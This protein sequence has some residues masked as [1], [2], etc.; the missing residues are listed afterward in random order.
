MSNTYKSTSISTWSI[1]VTGLVLVLLTTV[2]AAPLDPDNAAL[3]YYQ[4]F[5]LCP[6]IDSFPHEIV[7][8][9]YHGAESSEDIGEYRKYVEGYQHVIQ[10]V[11][12]ASNIQHCDW[13]IP[14]SIGWKVRAKLMPLTRS[15]SFL[16]A[17]NSRV[18]AA[19]GDYKAALSQCF[20]LRRVARHIAE[21]PGQ[22]N[23]I[24][25]VIEKA[26][27]LCVNR[28]LDIMPPDEITLK[29]LLG[30]LDADPPISESLSMGIKRDFERTIRAISKDGA[31]LSNLRKKLI[32]KATNEEQRNKAL[33]LTAEE[34][35][36]LIREP[37]VE[38]LDSVLVVLSSETTFEQKYARIQRLSEEYRKQAENNP[39]IVMTLKIDADTLPGLYAVQVT[40]TA[41]FNAIKAAVEIYLLKA[42]TGQ[43]PEAL[44][45]GLP[46][47]PLT[48]EG[49]EYKITEEGFILSSSCKSKDILRYDVPQYKFKVQEYGT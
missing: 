28:I 13:A 45:N 10:L 9:V 12:A 32:K 47:D 33:A 44:P 11:Q 2:Y 16:I 49:F 1:C 35:I 37:Y 5:L 46:K 30:Q 23:S 20:M 7:R 19:D 48:G 24:P 8:A 14:Y 17:V 29:W 18:L 25:V 40:H 43:L 21:D 27:L 26:T 36:R 6:D 22:S 38:F 34:L 15:L 42:K 31:L 41:R 4:A 39:A 3:L